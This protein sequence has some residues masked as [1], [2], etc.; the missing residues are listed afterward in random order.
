MLFF[1]WFLLLLRWERDYL[2]TSCAYIIQKQRGKVQ[3]C[4][5]FSAA[6]MFNCM[7]DYVLYCHFVRH[8]TRFSEVLKGEQS[9]SKRDE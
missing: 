7:F 4:E 8:R 5:T 6:G 3:L 9:R 1:L 2:A